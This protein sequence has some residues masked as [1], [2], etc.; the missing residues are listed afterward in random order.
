MGLFCV[1]MTVII[2][3]EVAMKRLKQDVKNGTF[4]NVYVVYGIDQ[5]LYQD[6]KR[7]FLKECVPLEEQEMNTVIYNLQESTLA[8]AIEDAE[9]FSFFGDKKVVFVEHAFFLTGD[10]TKGNE[11]DTTLLEQYIANPNEK[12]IF[13]LAVQSESL[14]KRKKIV[15]LLQQNAHVI[16]VNPLTQQEMQKYIV[17]YASEQDVTLDKYAQEELLIRTQANLGVMVQEI[18]KLML[19]ILP[20]TQIQKEDVINGVQPS[21]E[22]NVFALN[23]YLVDG[24]ITKAIAVYRDLILQKEEPVKLLA[25]LLSQYRLMYHIELLRLEGYQLNDIA[26]FLK[27]H[28]YRVQIVAKQSNRYQINQ[29]ANIIKLLIE[30]DYQLKSHPIDKNVLL[31]LVLLKI[32]EIR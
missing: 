25:I 7:R 24:K 28:P 6:V 9:S 26:S 4:L 23:E 32:S 10:K 22:N 14:D 5:Y 29:L 3:Y 21:L 20:R 12:T 18:D 16:E 30:T 11:Q 31:E 17:E 13:V 19:Q 8:S 2:N 15:K 27:Q 1:I